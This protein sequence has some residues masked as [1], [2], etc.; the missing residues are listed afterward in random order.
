V[1]DEGLRQFAGYNMKRAFLAVRTDFARTV[2]ALDLRMGTFS[3][4]GI[5]I[6]NP[7]ITQTQLG[8]ALSIERSGVVQLADELETAELITREKVPTDRRSYALRATLKGRRVWERAVAAVRA[9]EDRLMHD[10]SAEE[11]A[12]LIDFLQR[13]EGGTGNAPGG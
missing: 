3:A 13:I 4:L 9:H 10:L 11:R 8:Q 1:T 6:E 7:D 12:V 5:V 2:A